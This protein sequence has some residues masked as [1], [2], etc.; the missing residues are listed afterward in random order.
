MPFPIDEEKGSAKF[1]KT[2]KIL[3]VTLPVLPPPATHTHLPPAGLIQEDADVSDSDKTQPLENGSSETAR[4]DEEEGGLTPEGV[5]VGDPLLSESPPNISPTPAVDQEQQQPE[6]DTP[7]QAPQDDWT[8]TGEWVCPPF[9]YRQEDSVVVFCLHTASA[10]E[11]TL[12]KY[13]DEY[14]VSEL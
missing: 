14:F 10:K 9:S 8:S 12:V 5:S 11:K 4:A 2:K 7:V 3:T 13:F 6:V 1:D